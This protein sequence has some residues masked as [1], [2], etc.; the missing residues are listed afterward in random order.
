[1]FSALPGT[2]WS[3]FVPVPQGWKVASEVESRAHTLYEALEFPYSPLSAYAYV[4]G[5]QQQ[6]R[7]FAPLPPT[8]YAHYIVFVDG[9]LGR[10][11]TWNDRMTLDRSGAGL[12][13]DP[14]VKLTGWF[15]QPTIAF[16]EI[17]LASQVRKYEG[18]FG[19]TA[20]SVSLV[21]RWSLLKLTDGW[22]VERL[23]PFETEVMKRGV[24]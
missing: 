23:G 11:E 20:Q 2:P 13:Y 15:G 3:E 4:A 14:T 8:R 16:Q 22:K 17:F 18:Q 5:V 9:D 10:L 1:M 19:G 21:S 7:T 24:K 12:F 6:W